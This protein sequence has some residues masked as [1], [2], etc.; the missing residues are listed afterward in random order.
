MNNQEM[1][2][3]EI[4]DLVKKFCAEKL[5][6][7]YVDMAERLMAKL[8]RKRIN[9]MQV[10]KPEVWAAGIIHALGNIN[11]LFENSSKPHVTVEELNAFFKTKEALTVERSR[12]IREILN[13][14]CWN[15]EFCIHKIR[16]T[17]PF[18]KLVF[19]NG[20]LVPLNS[21]PLEYLD[22]VQYAKRE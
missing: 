3:R 5:N 17:N 10:G 11:L 19:I 13:L 4:L 1:K 20:C 6:D 7:E 9:P 16:L 21:L 12:Q 2:Q 15:D 22:A 8:S 14:G 18:N